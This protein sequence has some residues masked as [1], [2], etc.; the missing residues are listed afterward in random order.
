LAGKRTFSY[1][2]LCLYPFVLT[3]FDCLLIDGAFMF[4]V[5]TDFPMLLI[6]CMLIGWTRIGDGVDTNK[7]KA[8]V[9]PNE[10]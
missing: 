1:F 7:H 8:E 9:T 10:S 5:I 2:F 3:V 6:D 4:I